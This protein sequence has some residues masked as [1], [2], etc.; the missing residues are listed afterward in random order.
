MW[1]LTDVTARALSDKRTQSAYDEYLHIGCYVF[2]DSCANVAIGEALDTLSHGPHL[3]AAIA[4][5]R[6]GHRTHKATEEVARIRLGFLRL[7]NGGQTCTDAYR[8]FAELAH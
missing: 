5:I 4:L 2:F 1:T 6:A 3:P 8:V 7:T